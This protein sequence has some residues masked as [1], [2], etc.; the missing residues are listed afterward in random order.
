[1]GYVCLPAHD[2][3]HL[4]DD[5]TVIGTVRASGDGALLQ[6]L[7]LTWLTLREYL[8]A[9]C[10]ARELAEERRLVLASILVCAVLARHGRVCVYLGTGKRCLR[11][12]VGVDLRVVELSLELARAPRR[13][14]TATLL[15]DELKSVFVLSVPCHHVR[16]L[17]HLDSVN[18]Q[19]LLRMHEQS[20]LNLL[21]ARQQ[22]LLFV[23][24]TAAD[25]VAASLFSGCD[26]ATELG[27]VHHERL[28]LLHLAL[29]SHAEFFLVGIEDG[30]V[31]VRA[32][33]AAVTHERRD[34]TLLRH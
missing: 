22:M 4:R 10:C 15:L 26:I 16:S 29:L 31:V 17:H 11:S 28:L 21:A 3:G 12:G 27:L 6:L 1:M 32:L 24:W 9:G 33:G 18:H 5:S 30:D 23:Q 13:H 8:L 19:M 14:S 20:T 34:L 7:R 2:V 25:G